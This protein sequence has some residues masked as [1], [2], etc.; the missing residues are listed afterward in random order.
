MYYSYK[1][2]KDSQP[3]KAAQYLEYAQYCMDYLQNLTANPYYENMLIDAVYLAAMMNAEVGTNYD[4]SKFWNWIT[5]KSGSSVRNWG[6]V[7]YTQDGIDVYGMTGEPNNGYS[8]FFNSI[9][10]MTSI[11]PAAKYDP[12][13]ARMA[14]KWAINITN[15]MKYFLPNEWSEDH[16]TDG[17]YIGKTEANV[18][19]Y[20]SLR[21]NSNGKNFYATGDTKQNATS[22][23]MAGENTTNFGLYGGFYTGF[24]GALVEETNV[25][26]ILKLDCNK[27]DYY[28]GDMYETY[29]YYNPFM[30][31]KDV[32][33]DL[34]HQY[35]DL[36][37]SVSGQYLAKNVTGKQTLKMLAD[38]A[39]VIV[40]TKPNSQVEYDGNTTRINNK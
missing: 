16:Q 31:S 2:F 37:D 40:L 19:A 39:R 3:Q 15:A 36:Y 5:S 14:G 18:L 30:E 24:L 11:L 6:G 22:G 12:S 23:W 29:L 13:Y 34:G 8:Y 38:S 9:Y 1:I 4:I 21:K 27:T 35:Y 10:P 20:E 32:E 28:Q 26:G 33:I 7:N 17:D 25:E